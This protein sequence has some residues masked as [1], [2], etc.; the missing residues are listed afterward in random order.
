[1]ERPTTVK[2]LTAMLQKVDPEAAVH[3]M[4]CDCINPGNKIWTAADKSY[5]KGGILIGYGNPDRYLAKGFDL[6]ATA[7]QLPPQHPW[8]AE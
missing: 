7:P 1:M 2:E 4:G 8:E 3:L 5:Y 6:T